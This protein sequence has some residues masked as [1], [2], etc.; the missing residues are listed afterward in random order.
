ADAFPDGEQSETFKKRLV[1]VQKTSEKSE[2]VVSDFNLEHFGNGKEMF[3][4]QKA[5]L[6]FLEA[7]GGNALIAD[8]MGLGKTIQGLS[9]IAAHP[10]QRPAVIVCPAS[11]KLNWEREA[12]MWLETDDTIQVV[13]GGKPKPL[14]GDIVI[15]NYDILKKW[16]PTLKEYLPQILIFDESHSI[17]NSKSLRAK[18]AVELA[19]VVPHKIL[20][21]GTPVLN[22]P[23]E[24][25]NQ[26]RIIDPYKYPDSNFFQWHQRYC[27]AKKNR[28]GW[29]FSGASNLE[30]LAQS[31]KTIMIRRTK[32]QVLTELPEK[33]RS[34][35]FIPIDN[36]KEYQTAERNLQ[37]WLA[38]QEGLKPSKRVSSVEHLARIEYLRQIAVKGKLK[39]SLAWIKTFLEGVEKLVVFA[40]HKKII[41]ALME[42]FGEC[43]VKIDGSVSTEKRQEA[44]DKFQTDDQV[45]LFVGNI[46]AAGVGLT[47][48]AASNVAFLELPWTPGDLEQCEDRCHRIGQKNAVGIHYLLAKNTI[49]VTMAAMVEEKRGVISQI[50]DDK[51]SLGFNLFGGKNDE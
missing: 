30:E 42:E 13:K 6:E 27:D 23:T 3:P 50:T 46:K 12:E 5:G 44:V 29:D 51:N 20:L 41:S 16:V 31:L 11:L 33:Q 21:T 18:A 8:Q 37:E 48:T 39:Q 28:W 38:E 17:K 7:T 34:S 10:N 26:L 36:K 22:R 9:Y 1:D 24:L 32:D 35:I 25:W 49:D 45:K 40:T 15:I 47:L 4:F 19:E 43:A 2:R 14:T